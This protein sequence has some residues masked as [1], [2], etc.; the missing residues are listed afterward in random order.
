MGCIL[1]GEKGPPAQTA[2]NTIKI[3]CLGVG[4]CG[5]TTFLKQIK[6]IYQQKWDESELDNFK[7]VIRGNYINGMQ[8]VLDVAKRFGI[9]LNPENEDKA[10]I[11][12]SWRARTADLGPEQ[13]T[14]LKDLWADP[15]VQE[16]VKTHVEKL[17]VTHLAYFWDHLDRISKDDYMPEDEDIVRARL[18]TA[19]ASTVSVCVD[20]RWFEFMDVGGQKPERIKWEQLF[21]EHSFSSIIYFVAADEFDVEDEEKEFDRTKMEISRFIFREILTFDSIPSDIPIILFLNRED[22]FEARIKDP[23]GFK[24]FKTTFPDYKGNN[25]KEQGL[26]FI[27]EM[28]LPN[29]KDKATTHPLVCHYTCA[30]DRNGLFVIWKT[31]QQLILQRMLTVIGLV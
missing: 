3:L 5:K 14:I 6:I 17:T 11:L 30:L 15:A 22:L 24:A 18:R 7:K 27:K 23:A 16:V 31:V 21:K 9:A 20:K 19:G 8:D 1:G 4:G 26:A 10:R 13:I 29:A 28:F 12:A 2:S 25:T